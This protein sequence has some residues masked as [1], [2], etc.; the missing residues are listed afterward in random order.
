MML[1]SRSLKTTEHETYYVTDIQHAYDVYVSSFKNRSAKHVFTAIE[2]VYYAY[3][4]FFKKRWNTKH[5]I[6]LRFSM[7]TY[8]R[9]SAC[10]LL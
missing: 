3:V 2:Y 6:L 1:M 10:I 5:I 7:H 4:S 8:Y 9:G